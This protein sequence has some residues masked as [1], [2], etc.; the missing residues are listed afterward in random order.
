MSDNGTQHSELQKPKHFID[1]SSYEK[2]VDMACSSYV[3]RGAFELKTYRPDDDDY[4][5]LGVIG[6]TYISSDISH[7]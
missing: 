5:L 7:H 3:L 4:L 6:P 1:I 2:L